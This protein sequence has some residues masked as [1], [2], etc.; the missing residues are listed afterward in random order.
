[1]QAN[2]SLRADSATQQECGASCRWRDP[3]GRRRAWNRAKVDSFVFVLV[4]FLRID[5]AAESKN[6]ER[7]QPTKDAS[8][9]AAQKL[10][11]TVVV[12]FFFLLIFQLKELLLVRLA[13]VAL[14]HAVLLQLDSPP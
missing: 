11:T 3:L 6:C 2:I 13:V 12:H 10:L 1:G 7:R 4:F 14:E 8:G 9:L 5:C